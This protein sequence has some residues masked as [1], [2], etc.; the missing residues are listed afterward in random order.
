MINP[1]H[2]PFIL[3]GLRFAIAPI[4]LL[5]AAQDHHTSWP[6][7]T[8]YIIAV[9][10]D[11][12]DGII[13]RRLNVSTQKLR[14]A[15]SWADVCLYLSVALSTWLVHPQVILDFKLPLCVAIAAQLLLYL[16]SLIKFKQ[17][18]SFHTYTAKA[19]G[20]TLLI[21]TIALFGFNYSHTLWLAIVFCVVNSVEEIVMTFILPEWKCDVLSIYHAVKLRQ[22]LMAKSSGLTL[23]E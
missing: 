19:W 9:L 10:S 23:D 16:I 22:T 17:F 3:V 11:I 8:L 12:F 1:I 20:L 4:L 15:D 6:F 7:L 5:D 18:P 2:I 21:T 13:A 14:Q